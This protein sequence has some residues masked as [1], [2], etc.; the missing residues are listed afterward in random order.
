MALRLIQSETLKSIAD[1]IRAKTNKTAKMTPT[2][3]ATEIGTIS[4]G[5]ITPTGST[6]ITVNG[7]YDVTQYASAIVNVPT[8]GGGGGGELVLLASG[9]YTKTDSDA[10]VLTIPVSFTGTPKQ[11]Y[12]EATG[13]ST[14]ARTYDWIWFDVSD[15]LKSAY[16]SIFGSA[17]SLARHWYSGAIVSTV[18]KATV[19]VSGTEIQCGRISSTWPVRNIEYTYEIWGYA[20]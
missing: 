16:Q 17:I 14:Q 9:T 20:E 3:M 1:A 7:T 10:T 2:Q 6:T 18:E 15:V 5:G 13:S 4:G 12:V 11:V 8:G 19:T